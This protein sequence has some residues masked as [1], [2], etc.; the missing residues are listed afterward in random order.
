[1]KLGFE[2]HRR[3]VKVMN[4][5]R[6]TA[7]VGGKKCHFRSGLEYQWALYLEFLKRNREIRDWQFEKKLFNFQDFGYKKGPFMYRPDFTITGKDGLV[8]YQECKGHHDGATNAKFQR[9]AKCFPG[10]VMELVLQSI[11]KRSSKGAAR[12]GQASRYVRRI[13]D[14][15]VIFRQ[16]RGVINFELPKYQFLKKGTASYEENQKV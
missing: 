10:T 11:P 15:S 2:T 16:L 6:I 7:T 1:M 8:F 3:I 4:N 12:R 9:V 13:I 5:R 14:A